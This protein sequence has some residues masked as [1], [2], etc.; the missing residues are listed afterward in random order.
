MI[1]IEDI[2]SY[3]KSHPSSGAEGG[4]QTVIGNDKIQFSIIGGFCGLYGDF[5][6]TFEVAIFD[7]ET[8]EFR[9]R[10]FHPEAGDDVIAYMEKK[11]VEELV[12]KL[13]KNKDFQ[14]R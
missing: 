14:V 10:F 5:I 6:D 4:R 9:T 8:G 12:N 3:S 7:T 13:I 1:T 2:I 11:D